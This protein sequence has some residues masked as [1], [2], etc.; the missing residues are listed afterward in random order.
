MNFYKNA[1]ITVVGAGLSGCE[2]TWQLVKRGFKV[3]LYEMR[4]KVTTKAHKT[5]KFAELVC[6]NSFRGAALT[7][8]VGLLKEELKILGSLIMEAALESEV[9]AGGSLAVDR[10]V[11]SSYIHEKIQNHPN[12]EVINDEFLTIPETD[13]NNICIIATGPLTSITLSKEIQRITGKERLSFFDAISPVMLSETMDQSFMFRQSR[14]GKGSGDDYLNIPLNKDQYLKF[15]DDIVNAEKFGGHDEVESDSIEGLRPF[16]GCMPIEDMA[17]RGVDTLRHGPLK[18]TGLTDPKTGRWPYACVQLRQDDLAGNIYNIVGFQTRM[19]HPEQ[20]RIIRSLPGLENVEFARLGSVHRNSFIDSPKLLNP[21]LEMRDRKGL[22][23]AGQMTGVEGYVESTAGGLLAGINSALILSGKS[24]IIF[25]TNTAIGGLINYIT[26]SKRDY[27]QPMNISFGIIPSY[28]EQ[29]IE[30][31]EIKK[32][33]KKISKDERRL[34]VAKIALEECRR[35][36]S[37]CSI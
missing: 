1:V 33:G 11:F 36:W 19:R 22:F 7:N 4:P 12:V 23:F 3:S 21:T 29:E 25:P 13:H 28:F 9:P 5:E 35:L 26:D 30:A 18:P 10:E 27:F 17:M 16:E 20:I 32:K 8:A 31:G 37:N 6:S 24:P 2:A 15:I 14:Y 34:N